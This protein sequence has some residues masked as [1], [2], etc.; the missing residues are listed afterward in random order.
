V[1]IIA[2]GKITQQSVTLGVRQ[3]DRWEVSS[4]LKGDEVLAASRLNELA[5]GV[6]VR[7][8]TPG[9]AEGGAPGA[10]RDGA[11]SGAEGGRRG[12]QGGR[13]RG[14]AGRRGGTQ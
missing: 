14:G 8:T 1:Y 5:T 4:G 6:A 10:G 13:S 7:V 9:E 12:G 2:D 3:G 11:G